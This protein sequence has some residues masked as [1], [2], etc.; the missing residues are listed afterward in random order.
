MPKT[1]FF[2]NPLFYKGA[3]PWIIQI[4]STYHYCYTGGE[5]IKLRSADKITGLAVAKERS[6]WMAPP[7]T[8]HSREIWAP[9]IHF[10]E[11]RWYV[12][13]AA[14]DGENKNHRM[15]M[16]RS[17]SSDIES[18]FEYVGQIS[19]KSGKWAIDGTVLT[20]NGKMYFI[21]SGWEGDTNVAQNLYI[22]EMRSPIQIG[23]ERI[24]IS[25]PEYEWE[26]RGSGNGLPTINEGPQILKNDGTIFIIYS[27]SGSWSND[28]CL[29]MLELVGPDPLQPTSWQK[30]SQPVFS[31]TACVISPGHASFTK[32]GDQDWIVYH[33]NKMRDGGWNSRYIKMQ[34]FYWQDGRPLF[35][36]PVQ[37]GVVF[38]LNR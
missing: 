31:G 30:W 35:G 18:E 17:K 24:L 28:Y 14:D 27:A 5:S 19:D 20:S 25:R 26:K 1:E 4:E 22:A 15:H 6:I 37:D 2:I 33:A 16:L 36:K 29:G 11:N 38:P 9:E 23:S 32:I 21:W 10:L 34:P 13:F 7:N 12:Y 3:D 8:N